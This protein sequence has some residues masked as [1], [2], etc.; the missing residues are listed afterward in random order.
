MEWTGLLLDILQGGERSG[1]QTCGLAAAFWIILDQD[2]G[3][4]KTDALL[5]INCDV[6]GLLKCTGRWQLDIGVYP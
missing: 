6:R 1:G 3:K 2:E 4:W 5:K